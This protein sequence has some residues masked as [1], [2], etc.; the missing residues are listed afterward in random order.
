MTKHARKSPRLQPVERPPAAT[1]Q[2]PLPVLGA[3]AGIE[4]SYFELCIRAGQQVL[5]AMMEQDR[6]ELCGPRWKRDPER[7][8]GRAGTTS[9]EVT[10]GGRRIRMTRPRV[11]SQ[12]GEEVVAQ[13]RVRLTRDPL[14]ADRDRCVDP[15][16]GLFQQP[17]R[18]KSPAVDV[19]CPRCP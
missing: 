17:A 19:G 10:L 12:T 18:G 8:A 16:R 4:R 6:T 7:R 2:I 15:S 3:F 1:V 11:R 9:S 5:D 14:D 13:L